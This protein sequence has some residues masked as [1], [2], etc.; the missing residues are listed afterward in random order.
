MKNA[1]K[2]IFQQHL[3]QTA[4]PT[5]HLR[6]DEKTRQKQKT[7]QQLSLPDLCYTMVDL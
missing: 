6:Y 3:I 1:I 5:T 2:R 4:E 7:L